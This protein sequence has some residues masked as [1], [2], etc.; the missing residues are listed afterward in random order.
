MKPFDFL[1]AINV[2]KK[3][4]IVDST[5]EKEYIP[6]LMNR[7]LSYFPDT[8]LYANEMNQLH[9]LDNKP[10]FLFL[11][12]TVRPRKRF[13]KWHKSELEESIKII[14]VAYNYSHAKAKQVLN[15]F[16][17]EQL[18]IM[19]E[20]QQKGGMNTKEKNDVN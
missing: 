17:P 10:Q 12:N 16:T 20:K 19:R 1:D 14:S 8:I 6:F 2:T 9:F 15:L 4:L 3:D 11:L 13:S 5:T 18:N 7:G